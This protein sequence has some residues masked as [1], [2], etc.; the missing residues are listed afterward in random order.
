VQHSD[1]AWLVVPGWKGSKLISRSQQRTGSWADFVTDIG[2]HVAGEKEGRAVIPFQADWTDGDTQPRAGAHEL[3]GAR[4][5]ILSLDLD[6]CTDEQM[7]LACAKLDEHQVSYLCHSTHSYDPDERMKARIHI[8]LAAALLEAQVKPTKTR[9][10]AWLGLKTD[11]ATKGGHTLFYTPRCPPERLQD[12]FLLVR[13]GGP[14]YPELLPSLDSLPE[15]GRAAVKRAN[16]VVKAR[17]RESWPEPVRTKAELALAD[18]CE[19]IGEH[20]GTSI[21][22][23]LKGG[24]ATIAGYIASGLLDGADAYGKLQAAVKLRHSFGVDDQALAYRLEQIDGFMDWGAARPIVPWGYDANGEEV[25]KALDKLSTQLVDQRPD[26]LYTAPEAAEALYAFLRKQRMALQGLGLVEVSVGVGKTYA[27]RQLAKER[28]ERGEYTII[29]SLDHGLL[30]QIRRDLIEA[31]VAVRHLHSLVQPEARTGSPECSI[32]ARPDV[33]AMLK[34]GASLAGTVCPSCVHFRN[35]TCPAIE[36][37]RRKLSEYVLLAPYPLARRAIDLILEHG[38]GGGALIVCDEEPPGAERVE[39]SHEAVS[40]LLDSPDEF[41]QLL[42]SDQAH[43]VQCL[44]QSLKDGDH[45]DAPR[46]LLDGAIAYH[47]Q[48]HAPSL[49]VNDLRRWEFEIAATRAVLELAKGWDTLRSALV[50]VPDVGRVRVWRAEI[51]CDAWRILSEEG[52]FVLSATPDPLRYEEFPLLVD[53]LVLRVQDAQ[54]A[55]RTLVFTLHGSRRQVF[56]DGDVKWDIVADDLQ[57]LFRL[58]PTGRILLGTYKAISDGLKGEYAHL[59]QGRDVA[60]THYEV[61]RGRDDWRDRDVFCSLYTPRPTPDDTIAA[62]ESTARTDAAASRAL[63]QFHGRARDPQP[64][65]KP[66]IHY[67][68]GTVAPLSWNDLNSSVKKRGELFDSAPTTT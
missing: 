23:T 6:E 38:D 30:G 21:R 44:A 11:A 40:A 43:V 66:A 33:V 47:G 1:L 61:V 46:E 17:A 26:R 14:L 27:L 34:H 52:G 10:A 65:E 20:T 56:E 62:K 16:L 13:S 15:T 58:E 48:L 3:P 35:N 45:V 57:A 50:M 18:L 63:E 36:H 37:N 53:E 39:L 7:E 8:P 22:N 28:A 25:H 12:A 42:R 49:T 55:Q 2:A 5:T 41:W 19:H 64:R 24:V 51:E 67:C 31:G 32:R 59:L 9:L 29:L 68:F 60:L 4:W 54:P